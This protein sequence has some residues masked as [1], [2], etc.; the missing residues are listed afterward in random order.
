MCCRAQCAINK[1]L[2]AL[3]LNHIQM[4]LR[5]PINAIAMVHVLM[6]VV[7]LGVDGG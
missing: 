1:R 2:V 6:L 5:Q 3:I 7:V 4:L